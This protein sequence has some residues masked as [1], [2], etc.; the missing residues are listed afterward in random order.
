MRRNDLRSYGDER[1]LIALDLAIVKP[2]K[3]PPHFQLPPFH[4]PKSRRKRL[5]IIGESL[6]KAKLANLP[7]RVEALSKKTQELMAAKKK[8][9]EDRMKRKRKREET[10]L[11]KEREKRRK[12]ELEE[13]FKEIAEL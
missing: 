2:P 3:T 5:S 7:E 11:Q 4:N 13:N 9:I 8:T 12:L 6:S 10:E 1:W